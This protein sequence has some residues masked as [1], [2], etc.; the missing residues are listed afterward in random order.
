MQAFALWQRWVH[1]EL[2]K[3]GH[4]VVS[5]VIYRCIMPQ[6]CLLMHNATGPSMNEAIDTV[7]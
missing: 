3:A 4:D 7:Y 1:K 2:A 5:A 6:C